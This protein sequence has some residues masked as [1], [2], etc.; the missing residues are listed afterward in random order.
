MS[1]FISQNIQWEFHNTAV[2]I[3][4]HRLK[5]DNEFEWSDGT[6]WD[7][8]NFLNGFG[9]DSED[10]C[11]AIKPHSGGKW[12]TRPCLKIGER[13]PF[14]CKLSELEGMNEWNVYCLMRLN[15]NDQAFNTLFHTI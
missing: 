11:V 4:G 1:S 12:M 7:L 8:D 5:G 6:P 2:W 13:K 9:E 10:H 15:E 3:G 14:V